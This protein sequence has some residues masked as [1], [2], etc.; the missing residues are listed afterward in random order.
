MFFLQWRGYPIDNISNAILYDVVMCPYGEVRK[1][2]GKYM[3]VEDLRTMSVIKN[4]PRNSSTG[5]SHT[6]SSEAVHTAEN[7]GIRISS[8]NASHCLSSPIH[9]ASALR[10]VVDWTHCR[11]VVSGGGR[12]TTGS[13][14]L[15]KRILTGP[16]DRPPNVALNET[17][18]KGAFEEPPVERTGRECH[19]IRS[20]NSTSTK[21]ENSYATYPA[22][23]AHTVNGFSPSVGKYDDGTLIPFRP[24]APSY[25]MNVV[26]LRFDASAFLRDCPEVLE[27]TC[28]NE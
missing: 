14:Y 3:L 6:S 5:C 11:S 9:F 18:S 27:S 13:K 20:V 16:L 2:C 1:V 8:A 28:A 10:G 22:T 21:A 25:I 26:I 17:V 19:A 12:M 24:D 23:F 15:G 4:I 7:N